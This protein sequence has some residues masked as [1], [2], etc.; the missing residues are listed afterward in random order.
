MENAKELRVC[1]ALNCDRSY[2][3]AP[4]RL[5]LI[6]RYCSKKCRDREGLRRFR[7]ARGRRPRGRPRKVV[8]P[9]QQGE[10]AQQQ[11]QEQQGTA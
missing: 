8:A 7:D 2:K 11:Q 6:Q 10:G 4:G 1:Q 9:Q 3:P 5:G